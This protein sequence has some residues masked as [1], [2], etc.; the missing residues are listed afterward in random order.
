MSQFDQDHSFP[1]A[2]LETNRLEETP[3]P[4]VRQR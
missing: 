4:L 3:E 2:G 1:L